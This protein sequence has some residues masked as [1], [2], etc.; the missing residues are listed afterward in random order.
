M[1]LGSH[2]RAASAKK[3]RKMHK[4]LTTTIAFAFVAALAT[5]AQAN[6]RPVCNK[7]PG[8]WFN[9]KTGECHTAADR[10]SG[11]G[12]SPAR[13]P[14]DPAFVAFQEDCDVQGGQIYTAEEWNKMGYEP[15]LRPGQMQCYRAGSWTVN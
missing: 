4:F 1:Q 6:G 9:P 14:I 3:E 7:N 5:S 8:D 12:G 11:R 10:H 13:R 2:E 15:M